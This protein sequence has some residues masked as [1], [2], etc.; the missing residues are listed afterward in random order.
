MLDHLEHYGFTLVIAID[1]GP[2][3]VWGSGRLQQLFQI[4]ALRGG[5]RPVVSVDGTRWKS[6][7]ISH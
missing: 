2:P 1:A 3:A 7:L 6:R 5:E 4:D